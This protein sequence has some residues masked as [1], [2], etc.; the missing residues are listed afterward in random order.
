MTQVAWQFVNYANQKKGDFFKDDKWTFPEAAFADAAKQAGYNQGNWLKDA[1]GNPYKLVK[2]AKKLDNPSGQ[3][4]FDF[5]EL[6]SAGPDGKFDTAD[7]VTFVPAQNAQVAQSWWEA[8]ESRHVHDMQMHNRRHLRNQLQEQLMFQ[9]MDKDGIAR[10]ANGA[11]PFGGP[12]PE[13]KAERPLAPGQGIGGG[14]GGFPGAAPGDDKKGK[15]AGD[16]RS[17]GAAPPARLREYF[18]ETLLWQPALITD[19]HGVAQMNFNFADSITTW[20]LSA[21][22][23]SKGGALGGASVPLRVFQ[24][25]FVD[26]DL[27]VAL[28]QND[29]VAFPVA[30]YNYLKTPQTVKLEL[31]TNPMFELTDGEGLTRSLDLKPNEVTSVKFRIRAKKVGHFPLTGQGRAA[32]RRATPSSASSR[33]CRKARRRS[34]SSPTVSPA[35]WCRR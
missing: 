30:V 14:R 31:A 2:R 29:E 20:R 32:A 10:A 13:A 11:G 24:D 5:Y 23:S 7:D 19:E 17:G 8:D 16:N 22:A 35:T 9:H 18:P 6:V 28:T 27:P 1:W 34:R 15:E 12:M 33:W 21:T 25:F 3:P 26:I 4:Q